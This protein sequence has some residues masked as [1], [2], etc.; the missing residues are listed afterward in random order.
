MIGHRFLARHAA[1]FYFVI[2]NHLWL[3]SPS[4]AYNFSELIE[5]HAVDTYGQRLTKPIIL[6]FTDSSFFAR[7]FFN[8]ERHVVWRLSLPILSLLQESSST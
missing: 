7:Y 1:L 8:I 4:T 5:F 6:G 2:L 3:I